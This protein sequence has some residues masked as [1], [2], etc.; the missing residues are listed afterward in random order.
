[1]HLFVCR[2]ITA[3][4]L[5]LFL[6]HG[7]YASQQTANALDE[8]LS[9]LSHRYA[10]YSGWDLVTRAPGSLSSIKSSELARVIDKTALFFAE[11]PISEK[12]TALLNSK[13]GAYDTAALERLKAW[14]RSSQMAKAMSDERKLAYVNDFFNRLEYQSDQENWGQSDY[15]SSPIEFLA[16]NAGDCEDFA[17]AKYITLQA[18]GITADRMRITYVKSAT[19]SEPHMVL[20]YYATPDSMPLILDNLKKEILPASERSDLTPVFGFNG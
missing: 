9:A 11:I 8:H 3:L 14:L 19:Q 18:M 12:Q 16:R 17:I 15:W 1:M 10:L 7:L 5:T 20:A 6:S 4:L 2:F 13:P